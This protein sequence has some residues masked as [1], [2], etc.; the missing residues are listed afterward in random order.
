ML[1]GPLPSSL[2]LLRLLG[3]GLELSPGLLLPSSLQPSPLTQ[4]EWLAPDYQP[5]I[6]VAPN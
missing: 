5:H 1:A 6:D 2:R 3:E 4:N